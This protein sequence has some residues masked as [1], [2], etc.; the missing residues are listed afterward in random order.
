M[1]DFNLKEKEI[2][3]TMKYENSAPPHRKGINNDVLRWLERTANQLDAKYKIPGTRFKFGIDPI[4][5]IIPGI[6]DAVTMLF[7]S[8]LVLVMMK[9]GASGKVVVKMFGNILLDTIIGSIPIIGVIFDA[10]FKANNRNI[11]LLKE[12]YNEGKHRGS[13]TGLLILIGLIF[14]VILAVFILL[15]VWLIQWLI[16]LF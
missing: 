9:E 11:R 13:G 1:L 12:H 3:L 5:G 6:G 7:S 15:V 4:I 2:F 8:A 10:W 16:G 14:L